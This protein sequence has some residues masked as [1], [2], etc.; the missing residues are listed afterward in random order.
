MSRWLNF[1][2]PVPPGR[3]SAA[4]RKFCLRLTTA[5]G[6]VCVSECFLVRFVLFIAVSF[7]KDSSPKL[8]V[9]RFGGYWTL[10]TH[11]LASVRISTLWICWSKGWW[12]RWWKRLIYTNKQTLQSDRHYRHTNSQAWRRSCHSPN[13]NRAPE[14]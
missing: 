10:L 6:S 8:P 7:W 4:R 14:R 9:M 13:I 11:A 3:G 2:H 1:G 5:S 12:R